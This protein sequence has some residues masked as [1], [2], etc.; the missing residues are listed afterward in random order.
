MTYINP[1][2]QVIQGDEPDNSLGEMIARSSGYHTEKELTVSGTGAITSNILQLTGTV[3]VLSQWAMLTEV[4]T[5]TN[6]TN[7]YADLWGG[8]VIDTLCS[9]GA[10]LSGMPV[11]TYF[12]KDKVS[13][14]AYSIIDAATG[15]VLETLADRKSGR[16]FTVTQKAETD[17]FI[18]LH[19]TTTDS[20]ISFK[21]KVHFEYYPINGSTLVFL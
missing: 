3:I 18:R 5:L 1:L 7:M 9:D 12:T 13:T 2:P 15:G 6:L 19:L 10:V 20:P 16:P 11:G 17:T 8:S 14:E 21:V 4:T